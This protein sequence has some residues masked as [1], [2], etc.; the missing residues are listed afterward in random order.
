MPSLLAGKIGFDEKV[1]QGYDDKEIDGDKVPARALAVAR[2]VVAF[3]DTWKETPVFDLKPYEKDG[4]LVSS[5]GHLRWKEGQNKTDG[6]FT[7]NTDATKAVVGFAAGQTCSLGDVTIKPE[8]RFAAIYVTAQGKDET[9][10]SAKRLLVVAMARARN[11]GMKMNEA[12]DQL[13]DKGKAPILLEPVKAS[14]TIRRPGN[15]RVI[16][17]DHDGN[18]TDKTLPV[19][20]GT[21]AIDGAR[22]QTPYYLIAFE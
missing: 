13:L 1:V 15:P 8:S 2:A 16:P 18:R 3:T 12:G 17:L 7:M 20:N 4:F 19:S 9:I 21:F 6:F 11:T 22:D 14:I 5:T 10:S